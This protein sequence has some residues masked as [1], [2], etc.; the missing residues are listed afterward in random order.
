[1]L[2]YASNCATIIRYPKI[3]RAYY[4]FIILADE[5]YFLALSG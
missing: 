3:M 1:M 2:F 4:L 5:I